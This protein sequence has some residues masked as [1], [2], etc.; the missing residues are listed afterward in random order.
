[1]ENLWTFGAFPVDEATTKFFFGSRGLKII[2]ALDVHALSS[3]ASLDRGAPKHT[4]QRVPKIF[5]ASPRHL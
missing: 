5:R 2:R 4:I 3:G 1:V